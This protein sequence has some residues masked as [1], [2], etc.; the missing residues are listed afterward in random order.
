[1]RDRRGRETRSLNFEIVI[2]KCDINI[3]DLTREDL[4]KMKT[5]NQI[6]QKILLT[7]TIW[8][9][10]LDI[11]VAESYTIIYSGQIVLNGR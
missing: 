7:Y 11:G 5:V 10:C 8:C 6:L 4:K 2:K 9:I 3:F 1:M